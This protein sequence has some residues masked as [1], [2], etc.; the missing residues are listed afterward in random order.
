MVWCSCFIFP[1][2]MSAVALGQA[3]MR[4]PV[5]IPYVHTL[6]PVLTCMTLAAGGPCLPSSSLALLSI[7]GHV[8]ACMLRCRCAGRC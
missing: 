3:I 1:S 5:Y 4:L 6:P 7:P 2:F 8:V